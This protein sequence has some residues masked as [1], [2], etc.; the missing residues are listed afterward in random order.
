V[1]KLAAAW[2]DW[3]S[4]QGWGWQGWAAFA[5]VGTVGALF[6]L[7]FQAWLLRNQVVAEAAQRRQDDKRRR[8]DFQFEH[9]PLL[10]AVGTANIN[11]HGQQNVTVQLELRAEGDGVAYNVIA[12]LFGL[13]N[14]VRDGALGHPVVVNQ[15]RTPA[16]E[17]LTYTYALADL[18]HH[19][20]L[21]EALPHQVEL[22]VGFYNMFGQR[23]VFAHT[24]R[25]G[26]EGVEITDWPTFTWP[27]EFAGR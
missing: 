17:T 15:M 4:W 11:L 8:E 3:T 19:P 26:A 27:W 16:Q 1:I 9:T 25:V 21:L 12:N 22:E 7:G 13:Q 5:A 18:P 10:S 24:C 23:I 20:A 6:I 14:G 2:S